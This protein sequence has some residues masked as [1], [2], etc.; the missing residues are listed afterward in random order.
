MTP[1]TSLLSY[2]VRI[3]SVNP[4]LVPGAAGE[5]EV[6]GF[7]RGWLDEHGIR[8]DLCAAAPG[9][10]SVIGRVPGKGGG[11]SLLL[12]AHFDTVGVEGMP[13]AFNPRIADGRLYGRGAY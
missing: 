10:P 6:A 7:V 3:D 9:R 11:R 5:A 4:S 2:L 8:T 13:E 1:T 12:N